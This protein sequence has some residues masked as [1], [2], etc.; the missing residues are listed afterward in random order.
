[1]TDTLIVALT[2][3]GK[4]YGEG[5]GSVAAL[6][7]INLAVPSGSF[8]AVIGASGSGKST[9]LSI[10]GLLDVPTAGEYL[11]NGQDMGVTTRRERARL[12]A[13]GIGFVFQ[14][15]NLIAELT[16]LENVIV[17]LRYQGRPKRERMELATEAIARVELQNRMEFYPAEL[18]GGQQ[19]RVAIARAIAGGPSLLLAD[20]PTGSLDT[21][22]GQAIMELLASLN[23]QGTTICLVTHDPE[24]ARMATSGIE[25]KD[26]RIVREW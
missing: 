1:M 13:H 15:Y 22:N 18:S 6:A 21:T 9:L 3:V 2:N 11:F 20:E 5:T 17:P 14:A 10:L 8:M 7:A 25:L 26:G 24:C 16:V 4:D 19:Q 23:R 12:R